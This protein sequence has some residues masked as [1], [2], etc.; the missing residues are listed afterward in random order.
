MSWIISDI[1]GD[2][3][4]FCQILD[5][6]PNWRKDKVICTGDLCDRGSESAEVYK[7]LMTDLDIKAIKGNH[8]DMFAKSIFEKKLDI[9]QIWTKHNNGG[10]DTLK[11]FKDET[12][13]LKA[14]EFAHNLPLTY[15]ND[16][17]KKEGRFL[18]VSH[19]VIGNSYK[20]QKRF[21]NNFGVWE[22][23]NQKSFFEN[24]VLWG[25]LSSAKDNKEI[26]NICGHS[27][28]GFRKRNKNDPDP[29][30]PTIPRIKSFYSMIDT[31]CGFKNGVLTAIKFPEMEIVQVKSTS[32]WIPVR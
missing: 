16:S 12:S 1:H 9:Y 6:L 8:D 25:N 3:E 32:Q 22:D 31:G 13:L 11:S 20:T 17:L 10:E 21:I 2:Y 19:N 24:Q 30:D 5:K 4:A 26:Y 29:E 15:Q 23:P 14:A 28:S 18:F 7:R 27:Y